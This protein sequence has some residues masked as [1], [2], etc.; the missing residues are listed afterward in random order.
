MR[1]KNIVICALYKFTELKNH[2][3]LRT[4]LRNLMEQQGIRGTLLLAHEG[5]NGTVAGSR[6]AID[7]LLAFLKADPRLADLDYKE[8]Y[9]DTNPFYRTKVRLKKEIVRLDVEGIDPLRSAGTYVDPHDWN[10]LISDPETLLIDTRNEYE[11]GIGTFK[12]AI[13]PHT[14]SFREFPAYVQQQLD[15]KKHRKVAMFCTGGIRCEKSTAYL[16]EQ[17]F[18]EVYHLKGGILNYLEEIPPGESLWEGHCFVFDNRVAVD[19]SLKKGPYDQC[20]ACRMPITKADQQSPH[21]EQGVSCPHC[22]NKHSEVR[23]AR[24]RERERQNQLARERGE[25]HI[26]GEVH[27]YAKQHREAKKRTREAALKQVIKPDP[28]AV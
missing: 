5:I 3:E 21:Y 11:I 8:S 7:H 25:E 6:E 19:H 18:E 24:F 26:G 12:H 28:T 16:K 13:N 15:P 14:E 4:P 17:G 9:E 2:Q 10:A 1:M 22:Y 23:K 20:N 27:R